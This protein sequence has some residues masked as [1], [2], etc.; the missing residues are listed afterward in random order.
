MLGVFIAEKWIDRVVDVARVN[1][2]MMYVKL[3]IGM[4]IVNIF[5]AYAPQVRLSSEEKHDF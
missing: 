4:Q 2:R 1:E 5:S 3:V